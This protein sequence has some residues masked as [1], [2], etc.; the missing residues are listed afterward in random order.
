MTVGA[1]AAAH[2]VVAGAG[3][4]RLSRPVRSGDDVVARAGGG[5]RRGIAAVPAN[6]PSVRTFRFWMRTSSALGRVGDWS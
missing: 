4:D 1:R 6:T 3:V 5:G 2:R